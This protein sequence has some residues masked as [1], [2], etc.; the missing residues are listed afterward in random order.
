LKLLLLRR[1]LLELQG[2]LLLRLLLLL[3]CRMERVDAGW[4]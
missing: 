4:S 1:L 3:R 2:L